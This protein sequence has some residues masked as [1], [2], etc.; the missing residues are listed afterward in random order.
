M[1]FATLTTFLGWCSVLNLSLLLF[2][3]LMI[4]ALKGP[5]SRL[6]GHLLGIA[7]V[8]LLPIYLYY[9]GNYKMAIILFNLVP[10]LALKIMSLP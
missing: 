2:S 1:S 7:P 4:V 8:D 9:L 3:T 10:Y 5:L 6:H